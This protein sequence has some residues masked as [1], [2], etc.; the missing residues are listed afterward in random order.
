[1]VTFFGSCRK[2]VGLRRIVEIERNTGRPAAR[3]RAW[4]KAV[5]H[6]VVGLGRLLPCRESRAVASHYLLNHAAR[7]LS[8]QEPSPCRDG[9]SFPSVLRHRRYWWWTPSAE[10]DSSTTALHAAQAAMISASLCVEGSRAAASRHHHP[11]VATAVI[12][13]LSAQRIHHERTRSG[14]QAWRKQTLVGSNAQNFMAWLKSAALLSS[15]IVQLSC[16]LLAHVGLGGRH[17][18]DVMTPGSPANEQCENSD[19]L[20][21]LVSVETSRKRQPEAA[22]SAR[23]KRWPTGVLQASSLCDPSPQGAMIWQMDRQCAIPIS[24]CLGE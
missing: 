10:Q 19:R 23:G 6:H 24:T 5:Q 16:S 17:P 11:A 18:C 9:W 1:M 22:T 2:K 7:L 14:R 12:Q 20:P 8:L 15:Q 21:V 13:W 3:S 4:H